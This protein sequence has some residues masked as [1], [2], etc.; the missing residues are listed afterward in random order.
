MPRSM[1]LGSKINNRETNEVRGF[2]FNSSFD[3]RLAVILGGLFL[4]AVIAARAL[5]EVPAVPPGYKTEDE[6]KQAFLA[7]K[8]QPVDLTIAVP[9]TVSV[10]KDIEFGKGGEVS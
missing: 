6:V 4:L 10:Q 9:D 2:N 7:G 1:K 3:Y 5:A 8:L